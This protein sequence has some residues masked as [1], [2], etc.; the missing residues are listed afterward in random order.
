MKGANGTCLGLLGWL[1]G[2][3]GRVGWL[4]E[5]RFVRRHRMGGLTI[6]TVRFLERAIFRFCSFHTVD[7]QYFSMVILV[8]LTGWVI[9]Q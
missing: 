8:D 7:L 4:V 6:L 3:V 2:C 5:M 9:L 1:A